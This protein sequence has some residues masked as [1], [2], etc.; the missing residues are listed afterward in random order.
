MNS[1][2][3]WCHR[4]PFQD[5]SEIE[6]KLRKLTQLKS[7]LEQNPFESLRQQLHQKDDNGSLTEIDG[8]EAEF[9]TMISKLN[10]ICEMLAS[11]W[12]AQC[13]FDELQKE[14]EDLQ[15]QWRGEMEK[16]TRL[17]DECDTA[18][19]FEI[20]TENLSNSLR[21]PQSIG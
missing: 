13:K 2:K 1:V 15:A 5:A 16:L 8:L 7:S 21:F 4:P 12:T 19:Q 18:F 3:N 20:T 14:I 10:A 9:R 17:F 6:A 11:T